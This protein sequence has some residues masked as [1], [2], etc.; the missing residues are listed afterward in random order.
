MA[1]NN[2][3]IQDIDLI[4]TGKNGDLK[5]DAV[6][7]ALDGSLFADSPKAYYKHLCGEYPTAMSFALW[8]ASNM[9]KRGEVPAI[10]ADGD[11]KN[12]SP[13]KI[14]IYNHYQNSYHSLMLLSAC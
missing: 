3:T 11:I 1:K 13:K 5:N 12:A 10:V 7:E 14:L 6:Y 9:I 8:L 2:L 4:I